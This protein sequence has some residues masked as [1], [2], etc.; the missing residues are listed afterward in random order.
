MPYAENNVTKIFY[1]IEGKGPPIVLQHGLAGTHLD[2]IRYT[3]YVKALKDKH[4]LI[5]LDARGRGK[6]DKPHEPEMHSMKNYVE[7]ITAILDDIGLEKA[8]FWGYSFGG[9]VGLAAGVYASERF[10][11]LIIGGAGMIEKD[12]PDFSEYMQEYIQDY[13]ARLPVYGKSVE[14]VT[15]HIVET[16]GNNMHDYTVERWMNADPRALLAYCN[17][18]ENIGL[19]DVLPTISTPCLLYAGDLDIIPHK[20]SKMCDEIMQNS[21]FVSLSGLTHGQGFT[22]MEVVLPHVLSF[23]ESIT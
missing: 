20:Y 4:K 5:L 11:S 14:E 7:D 21:K 6:S 22:Q 23:L 2:W 17:Y 15:A 3:D 9:R 10:S 12:S 19:K 8:H 13:Y 16:R 18:I 1:K